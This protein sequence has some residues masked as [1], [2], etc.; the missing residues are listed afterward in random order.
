MLSH[1]WSLPVC[2]YSLTPSPGSLVLTH[3]IV[4]IIVFI[5]IH[6]ENIDQAAGV[7]QT[8]SGCESCPPE[9]KSI[10]DNISGSKVQTCSSLGLPPSTHGMKP[11]KHRHLPA[12][13]LILSI[14]L[15]ALPLWALCSLGPPPHFHLEFLAWACQGPPQLY[16]PGPHELPVHSAPVL[17]SEFRALFLT[18]PSASSSHS[19]FLWV[20]VL[21]DGPQTRRGPRD[22]SRCAPE[23]KLSQ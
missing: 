8:L 2:C 7:G 20:K 5:L 10:W 23:Q 4:N 9:E 3:F 16:H 22:P 1:F 12:L 11:G 17:G 15:P 21:I 14:L 6:S 19:P 13:W 18:F